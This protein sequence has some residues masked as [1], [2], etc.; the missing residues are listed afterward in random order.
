[1]AVYVW[2]LVN[3]WIGA[4]ATRGAGADSFDFVP[5][6][7]FSFEDKLEVNE[8]DASI[9]KL[10][11]TTGVCGKKRWA[12]GDLEG[13]VGVNKM[14]YFFKNILWEVSSAETADSSGAYKHTFSLAHN[15]LHPS[16]ALALVEPNQNVVFPLAM[17]E[18]LSIT[19]EPGKCL[20]FKASFKSKPSKTASNTA[21]YE[22]DYNLNANNLSVKIADTVDDLANATALDLLNFEVKFAQATEEVY[23]VGSEEVEEI[24]NQT[25]E[26]TGSFEMVYDSNEW[27]DV[28]LN[29]QE[30]A[31]EID[32]VDLWTTIGSNNDNPSL[33]I[34]VNKVFLQ[35]WARSVDNDEIVKQTLWFKA[36]YDIANDTLVNVELVNTK[37]AY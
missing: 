5:K 18:E 37:S 10:A 7:S 16:L 19:W 28:Y 20:N 11:K 4:E 14:G 33:K 24:Y 26:I 3:V 2:R 30:K 32:I 29:N 17:L 27:K 35:D 9:G 31:L 8:N 22:T 21:S 15:N 23:V 34:V 12:E 13:N 36:I 25:V 1:M 6:L